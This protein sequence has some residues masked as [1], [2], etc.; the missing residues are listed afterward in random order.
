MDISLRSFDFK[1]DL[2][3]QRELFK[4]CFP[5]TVG[6]SIQSEAH[7]IWKFHSLGTPSSW[8]Y[9]CENGEELVGYYAALPYKYKIGGVFTIVGM[10]CDVMTS[11][12]YRGKG[13]FTKLGNYSTR[14]LS[15]DVPFTMGYPIRPDVIP[16]HL[17]IGWKVAFR[18]PLYIK[19]VKSDSLLKRYRLKLFCPI[20]NVF[21]KFYNNIV[22]Q[23]ANN[24]YSSFIYND[25]ENVC[26][27][28]KFIDKWQSIVDNVL[29]KNIYFYKWRFGAPGREYIF[30]AVKKEEKTVGLVVLRQIVKYEVPTLCIIDYMVIPGHEKCH[31][32]IN[33]SLKELAILKNAEAL[34]TM[35]SKVSAR[36][37]KLINN[38]FFRSPFSFKL[39]IKNLTNKFSNDQLFDKKRW[40]LMWVDSDDL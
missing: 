18:L 15:Y 6:D 38:G 14:E 13:I 5:E 17:K 32:N 9:I 30:L 2:R 29:V 26:D 4:D 3:R 33:K 40:H 7:Y 24:K 34:M 31:G 16:G 36:K 11:S 19:F 23:R 1:L 8:E 12:K 25:L 22:K 37:Y 10:V 39:I 27:F 20:V 21:L 35:M 28:E